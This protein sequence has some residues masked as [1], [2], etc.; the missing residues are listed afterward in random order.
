MCRHSPGLAE[1]TLRLP[2]RLRAGVSPLPWRAHEMGG[3][4]AVAALVA[5]HDVGVERVAGKLFLPVA[6]LSKAAFAVGEGW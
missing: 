1:S 5:W 6:L 3:V 4:G 2:C